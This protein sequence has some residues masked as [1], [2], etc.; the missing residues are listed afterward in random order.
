MGSKYISKPKE[1]PA[2]GSY[3]PDPGLKHTKERKYEAF[4]LSYKKKEGEL[5][6]GVMPE[7]EE[8]SDPGRYNY[9]IISFGQ[10]C[11]STATMGS[12]YV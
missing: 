4:F 12:K 3:N 10:D 7:N 9:N 6:D 1:G 8:T 5:L 2:P 11:K